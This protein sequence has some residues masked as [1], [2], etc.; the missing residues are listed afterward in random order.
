VP[1]P[2][3]SPHRDPPP[4]DEPPHRDGQPRWTPR[5]IR[6]VVLIAALLLLPLVVG[7]VGVRELIVFD[8]LPL[9]RAHLRDF[10]IMWTNLERA[11]KPDLLI[12]GD[13]VAQQDID[14]AVLARAIET[15]TGVHIVAFDAASAGAGY[16]V[17]AAIVKQLARE[18]RLPRVALIVIQPGSLQGINQADQS[19]FASPLGELLAGCGV[20]NDINQWLNCEL[21]SVS[22][23]WRWRGTPDRIAGAVVR[24]VLQTSQG[25][26]LHLRVDGFREGEARP[27]ARIRQQAKQWTA[28]QPGELRLATA[29]LADF[30]DLVDLLRTNGVA[31]I[32]VSMPENPI[33]TS[34]L[35]TKVPDWEGARRRAVTSMAR[36]TATQVV[37]VT[38]F[39]RWY[40]DGSSRDV[41]HLS[42]SGAEHFA[43]Q[44]WSLP[45]FREAITRG[46]GL[47]ASRGCP[48]V[49]CSSSRSDQP[50]GAASAVML[51]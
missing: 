17:S 30:R 32:P 31:V 18:G 20:T 34:A 2:R 39:G 48:T 46:L 6:R 15:A 21:S 28:G 10:E 1:Q 50:P 24:P 26:G 3:V 16:R 37:Y 13:S 42:R 51:P 45:E 23:L 11:P 29:A 40:G 8:R 47:T 43:F 4:W 41:K 25:N 35:L 14:P 33:L 19:F 36:A 49:S 38:A 27:A 7:E 9:A 22:A 44:L 12:L 5:R